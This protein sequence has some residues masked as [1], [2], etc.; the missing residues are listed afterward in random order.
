[1]TVQD[2]NDVARFG[3]ATFE[4]FDCLR[5]ELDLGQR[6]GVKLVAQDPG[7][8]A[9]PQ[10]VEVDGDRRGGGEVYQLAQRRIT[11][12]VTA[13][14]TAEPLVG[15]TV[16]IPGTPFRNRCSCLPSSVTSFGA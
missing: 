11:G 3:E 8:P 15:A 1:M 6:L 13:Q 2:R 14:D 10:R 4:A 16:T 12:R 5:R 9:L 7:Q